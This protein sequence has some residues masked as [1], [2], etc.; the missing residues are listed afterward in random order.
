MNNKKHY[1]YANV[2]DKAIEEFDSREAAETWLADRK[3]EFIAANSDE[4]WLNDGGAILD[5]LYIVQDR[6]TGTEIERFAFEHDAE[7][8]IAKLESEDRA[9]DAYEED[10]YEVVEVEA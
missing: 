10:F 5:T 8:Y 4:A 9:N 3:A 2:Y 1:A 6:Q 7:K